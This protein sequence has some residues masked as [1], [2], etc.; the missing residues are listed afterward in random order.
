MFKVFK[1]TAILCSVFIACVGSIHAQ[2]GMEPLPAH[3]LSIGASFGLADIWG[4]VGTSS[5]TDH[6]NNGLYFRNTHYMGGLF[7]RYSLL[8]AVSAR[9]AINTGTVYVTDEFNHKLASKSDDPYS[10]PNLL[11]LRNQDAKTNITEGLL[12]LEISPL[13]LFPRSQLSRWNFQPILMVGL[14]IFHFNPKTTYKN[15]DGDV[16]WVE[17]HSLHLEGEG[18][19]YTGAPKGYKLTQM[20]IPFGG[21]FRYEISPAVAV[22]FEY[23]VR[24]T[25]TDYLDGVSDRYVD[26][27]VFQQYLNN[28]DAVVAT[29]V[30][31][32]TNQLDPTLTHPKGDIRGTPK[33][34]DA[35]S[36]LG[37]NLTI[38]FP[39]RP[40]SIY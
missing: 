37:F 1:K 34:N 4:D 30:Y 25:F 18:M 3:E 27:A 13:R 7:L 23:L 40:P 16:N 24:F 35:Y 19:S 28:A 31:N 5:F 20:A 26:P 11:Y 32:K 8:P 9:L 12:Q 17:T 21:G 6:Y 29:Q 38:R 15:A 2:E 36:T 33:H 39:K 14:G 22:G 10:L